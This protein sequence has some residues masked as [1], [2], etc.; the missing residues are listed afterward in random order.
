MR[1][2]TFGEAGDENPDVDR[3]GRIVVSRKHMQFDIWKFR[4]TEIRGKRAARATHYSPNRQ[5]Q[6]PSLGP[7][8]RELVYLSDNGGMQPV[9]H[10]IGNRRDP[11]NH[12]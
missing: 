4:S 2:L 6:T 9:D 3:D 12:L 5:V 8:D 1:Q 10:E 7:N 11:S